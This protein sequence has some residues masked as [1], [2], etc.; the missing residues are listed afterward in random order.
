VRVEEMINYFT[1][2]YPQ[3]SDGR[4][5]AVHLDVASCPWETSHR[6]VR[7]GLKGKEIATDKRGPSNL[8]FLLDIS[9]SMTP[10]ERLPLIKQSMRLLVEK[11][12]E[13]DR[14]AIVVYAGAS[15]LALPSTTGDHKEQIFS[16]L[17]NLQPGGSPNGAEGIELAYKVAADHFIKGGVNRVILATDG[18]FNIGGTSQGAA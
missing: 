6:L 7:I 11:L 12:T 1:Y 4:P 9:G 3:P 13:N 10:A 15:G 5:F 14:V 18:H 8:V 2:D 17:E 16:A